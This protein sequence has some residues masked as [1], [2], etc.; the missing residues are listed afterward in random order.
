MWQFVIK[1]RAHRIPPSSGMGAWFAGRFDGMLGEVHG[2]GHVRMN[3]EY[4]R[5]NLAESAFKSSPAFRDCSEKLL[6]FLCDLTVF[7]S[8]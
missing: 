3:D 7:L 4:R 8:G 2:K 6:N 1:R 5:A